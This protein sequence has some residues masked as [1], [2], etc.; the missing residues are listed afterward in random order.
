MNA[1]LNNRIKPQKEVDYPESDGEPLGRNGFTRTGNGLFVRRVARLLSP[2]SYDL[3]GDGQ[4]PVL[5][6]E[7]VIPNPSISPDVYVV[8]GAPKM[9]PRRT[10]KVWE[11]GGRAGRRRCLKSPFKKVRKVLDLWQEEK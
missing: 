6:G 4:L 9:P 2:R 1:I 7:S 8:K 10:F 5:Q 11:E 3:R